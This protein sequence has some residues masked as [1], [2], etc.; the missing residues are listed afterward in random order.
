MIMAKTKSQKAMEKELAKN[1]TCE[2]DPDCDCEVVEAAPTVEGV[3]AQGLQAMSEKDV[4]DYME[5]LIQA[6]QPPAHLP[7]LE[8][9]A[10]AQYR[11]AIQQSGNTERQLTRAQAQV[12]GLK[13]QISRLQ[14]Q[15]EAFV[16]LLIMAEDTRRAEAKA[17]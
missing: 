10:L 7:Q 8:L 13:A 9:V 6:Q 12:E 5:T 4:N 11:A 1:P 16:N 17:K 3:K 2:N 14:G 15:S